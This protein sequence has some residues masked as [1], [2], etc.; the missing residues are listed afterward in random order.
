MLAVLAFVLVLFSFLSSYALYFFGGLGLLAALSILWLR[1]MWGIYGMAATFPFL[2][3]QIVIGGF[4]AP[5]VD[6]IALLLFVVFCLQIFVNYLYGKKIFKFNELIGFW[7]FLIFFIAGALSLYNLSVADLNSSIKYLLRPILYFYLMFVFLPVHYIQDREEVVKII[8][9]IFYVALTSAVLGLWKFVFFDTNLGLRRT[10][11]FGFGSFYPLGYNHNLLSE[12]LVAVFP[13]GL[14]IIHYAKDHF[15]KLLGVMTTGLIGLSAFLTFSRSGWL[16][17][18]VEAVLIIYLLF[19]DKVGVKVYKTLLTLSSLA[20]IPFVILLYYLN[21]T[22][23]A[24]GSNLN[25]LKLIEIAFDLFKAHPIVGSGVGIFFRTVEQVQWYIIEYGGALD[26]HGVFFKVL[27]ETGIMGVVGF[28]GFLIYSLWYIFS[29]FRKLDNE[30]SKIILGALLVS[31]IGILVFEWFGTSY[32]VAKMWF[33][34]GLALAF[35][36]SIRMSINNKRV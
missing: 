33:F 9:I 29:T 27:S 7:W 15:Y 22:P 36:H 32:Y 4:N 19:K 26:A 13:F 6:V 35:A 17:L 12:A 23:I 11:P 20:I 8:K 34:Y 18:I 5:V 31:C 3:W 25:R 30:S 16:V 21:S 28:F 1:P 24:Q 10:L 14:V 2:Q